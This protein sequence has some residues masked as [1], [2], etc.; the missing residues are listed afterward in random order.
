[1]VPAG[2]QNGHKME[3]K[4]DVYGTL[5]KTQIFIDVSYEITGFRLQAT[6]KTDSKSFPKIAPEIRG[7]TNHTFLQTA[8]FWDPQGTPNRSQNRLPPLPPT[9]LGAL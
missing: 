9:S 1:M 6:P 2:F 8:G 3:V 4:C 7:S 5:A